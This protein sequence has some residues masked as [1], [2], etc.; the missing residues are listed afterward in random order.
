MKTQLLLTR[1]PIDESALVAARQISSAA[2]AVVCFA[3]MVRGLEG[4]KRIA[5]LEYESFELMARHQFQILFD[6]IGRRWPIESIRLV[7][8]LGVVGVNKPS[9]WVEVVA[10]HRQEAFAACEYLID[11]MKQLVPMWKKAVPGP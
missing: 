5:A 8:R 6:E 7:H 3:G 4:E 9:L 10:A 2:G 11:A 1:E